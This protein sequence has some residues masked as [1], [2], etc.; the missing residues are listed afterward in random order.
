MRILI[1]DGSAEVTDMLQEILPVNGH[2]ATAA[3][4]LEEVIAARRERMFDAYIIDLDF[5]NCG[6]PAVLGSLRR[7]GEAPRSRSGH[8]MDGFPRHVAGQPLQVFVRRVLGEAR[9]ASDAAGGAG[10]R[11]LPGVPRRVGEAVLPRALPA[12]GKPPLTCWGQRALGIQSNGAK[13]G[14]NSQG[15]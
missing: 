2:T 12:A 8:R 1:A 4:I 10:V 6:G 14:V 9:F 11:P 7:E 13:G 5:I 3:L 15:Q